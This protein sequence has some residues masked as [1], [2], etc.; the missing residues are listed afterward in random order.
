M[1]QNDIRKLL[2]RN[3]IVTYAMCGVAVVAMLL[4]YLTSIKSVDESRK[5][6]YMVRTDGE[7]V[8][9]Q[10]VNR[11]ENLAVEMKHHVFM[12]VENFYTLNQFTWED[13]IEKALW[14]GNMEQLHIRRTNEG[15]Y[16]RFI[17]FGV[18]QKAG[19]DPGHI[20]LLLDGNGKA[21]FRIMIDLW[22]KVGTKEVSYVIF[23]K[24]TLRQTD[25]QFPHN[26]HGLYIENYIEEKVVLSSDLQ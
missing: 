24:G 25:R 19:L 15:Y 2:V 5:Y 22:E 6:L 13:H 3:S 4:T 21:Q 18:E 11:R 20:E 14:L 16:N 17:Q 8:P 12:F 1:I 9:M 10:W 23:A 26:P 7:V